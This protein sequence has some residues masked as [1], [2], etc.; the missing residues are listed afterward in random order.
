MEHA[1]LFILFLVG[2]S[3]ALRLYPTPLNP[4]DNPDYSRYAVKHPTQASFDNK[5]KFATLR[6]FQINESSVV[7]NFSADLKK[8]CLDSTTSMG[9][10]VWPMY[11]LLFTTNFESVID[12]IVQN[13][14]FVTDIWAFVPG[15]GPGNGSRW[16][17]NVW[18]QFYP[19]PQVLDYL[20]KVLGDKWLGMDIG[21]QDGR[22]IGG[23]ADQAIPL[24]QDRRLQFLNFR[25]HFKGME[26]ILGP[27]LVALMSL[28]FPHYM[29]KTGLYTMVGAEAAQALPN[30]QVFYAFIR[31]AGKQY[32]VLWFGNVSVYNRFGYKTYP[33]TSYLPPRKQSGLQDNRQDR[34]S[35]S[36]NYT[37][38]SQGEGGPKCGTSLNLMKRLM[39]A[40]IMY[41]SG[42]VSFENGW[43]VGSTATL[44]PIGMMQHAASEFID[45]IGP[46]GVH[47][48]TV[49]LYLDY[50]TG[51]CPPRHLYSGNL[52]RSWGNLPYSMGDYLADG[53]LRTVYPQYQ[54]SSYFHNETGFSSPTPY[55]DTLDVV[56]SDSPPW[57]LSQ[58]NTL[59]VASN[60]TGGQE[61]KDNL[62]QFVL[63]GGKV[64][65]TAGNIATLPNG[66]LGVSSTLE[67]HPLHSG[68][69]VYIYTGKTI[70]E[71]YNMSVCKLD[72]PP[73]CTILAKLSDSTPLVVKLPFDGGGS[74]IVF[75]T[76][77]AISSN[78]V[79][80]PSSLIDVT[81]PSPYPLLDHARVL[82]DVILTNATL[83]T[84]SA[85]L[86]LVPTYID[87]DHFYLLVSNP[88][89]KQQPLKLLSPQGTITSVEEVPLD[90]S[91][92]G[93]VGYLPDGFEGT[94]IGHST[95]TTIAG[96]DTRLFKL[97]LSSDSLHILPKVKPKPR[98]TGVALHLRHIDHSIRY[99]I[100]L[101]PSFFQHYDSIV[102][103]YSYLITKDED[104]L[105][106]E[107]Q[108]LQQQKVSVY[109]D[110]SPSIDLFPNLRLV[111][112]S[113][114]PFNQSFQSMLAL[115]KKMNVLGSSELILSLHRIP[116][117]DITT[118][119][120]L[121]SFNT[122]LHLL[123]MYA[124]E[125]GVQLHMQDAVKNPFTNELDLSLWLNVSGLSSMK[126]VL[127]TAIL[128][129]QELTPTLEALIAQHSSI[130][131]I[132][133]PAFDMFNTRY[134]VNIPVANTDPST[135]NRLQVLIQK[136]C[137]LR[138]YCPYSSSTHTASE[139]IYPL[140]TDGYFM[141]PDE[142]YLDVRF[143]ENILYV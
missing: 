81:L 74:L 132:N 21:E 94:D 128:L 18:Q 113:A 3:A 40:H 57:T 121:A 116:E 143:L 92:K 114:I 68:A 63:G 87:E 135:Q 137:S 31:G 90:Q 11:P 101:R 85:N 119:Q 78:V 17:E 124:S 48:T 142:E 60:H 64:V 16:R 61:V 130:V 84:S 73:N 140:V 93:A 53:T 36:R 27:K 14:L 7:V 72:F 95:N 62:E 47:I 120:T 22:Y 28:T 41:G 39:Y 52:Y 131:L 100:L 80:K 134:S 129:E 65:I 19:P 34:P 86:S 32:G 118:F 126:I 35:I 58:Y 122:T 15:S 46:L 111:N 50:F 66:L 70:V 83:F 91:E 24:N 109:V 136:M 42:Y 12:V 37:C 71:S 54:D 107:S 44:S 20:Q 79:A 4:E 6:G 110:A 67:C 123:L 127:N 106:Q 49:G 75:A 76:P 45:S 9:T 117:N 102:V 139:T 1:W 2:H 89:L 138:G 133:A 103:D 33:E 96:V 98:P 30:S 77:F 51:F 125:L 13:E 43:F 97:T 108:W 99:E 112:N 8:Y 59:I 38:S 141:T 88:E 82:L 25:S 104:F 5:T 23:Y 115:M 55:G 69:Q 26:D 10:I 56:L 105:R 29:A